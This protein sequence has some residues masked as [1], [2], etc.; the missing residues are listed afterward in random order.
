[1][2]IQTVLFS[3]EQ[4]VQ[5]VVSE[6]CLTIKAL[7]LPAGESL[8][9]HQTANLLYL[10][11]LEGSP[12]ITVFGATPTDPDET[13]ILAPSMLMRIEASRPHA[14]NAG[15]QHALLLLHLVSL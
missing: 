15:E 1:M 13:V 3:T 7:S 5:S 8:K 14:V 6:G 12:V 9:K 4:Q 10:Q 2:S 11:C